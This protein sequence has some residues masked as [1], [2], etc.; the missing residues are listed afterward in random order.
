MLV[1]FDN[2][3]IKLFD[4]TANDFLNLI[5]MKMTKTLRNIALPYTTYGDD[6][7]VLLLRRS[8]S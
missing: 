7:N 2:D 6:D 1:N 8:I 5:K 4:F 3:I